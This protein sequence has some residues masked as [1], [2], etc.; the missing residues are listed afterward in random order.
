M[1]IGAIA[2]GEAERGTDARCAGGNKERLE[3]ECSCRSWSEAEEFLDPIGDHLQNEWFPID[4][5][6]G[7]DTVGQEPHRDLDGNYRL[8]SVDE[9]S[10]IKFSGTGHRT[11]NLG[12]KPLFE[13]LDHRDQHPI[14]GAEIT[15][16]IGPIESGPFLEQAV[17]DVL[18]R[19]AKKKFDARVD[20]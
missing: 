17:G 14:A 9:R 8:G 11:G 20:K 13:F 1:D 2:I 3:C 18:D 10:C 12:G 4:E 6:L 19:V 16:D 5:F 15:G 7:G